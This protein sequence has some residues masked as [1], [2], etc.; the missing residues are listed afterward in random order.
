MNTKQELEHENPWAETLKRYPR[1]QALRRFG[2]TIHARPRKGPVLWGKGGR[3]FTE[4]E[5]LVICDRLEA[6]A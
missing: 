4:A 3:I 5:A 1:D 2:F 6:Q